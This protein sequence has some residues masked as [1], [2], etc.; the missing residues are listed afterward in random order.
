MQSAGYAGGPKNKKIYS[1]MT[2]N[3]MVDLRI[4]RH[5][6]AIQTYFHLLTIH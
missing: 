2:N 6:C 4:I 3:T 5:I 1:D